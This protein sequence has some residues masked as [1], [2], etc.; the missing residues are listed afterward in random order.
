MRG[1]SLLENTYGPGPEYKID[2]TRPFY[3][4]HD[5]SE[6]GQDRFTANRVMLY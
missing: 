1:N 5:Y 3:V 4:R 6:G 2:T